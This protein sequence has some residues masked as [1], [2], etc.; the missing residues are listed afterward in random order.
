MLGALPDQ[1]C[2]GRTLLRYIQPKPSPPLLP[3]HLVG[4]K[5][6]SLVAEGVLDAVLKDVLGCVV[7]NGREGIVQQHQVATEVGTAGQVEA[8]TLTSRQVDSAQTS[9]PQQGLHG[10]RGEQILYIHQS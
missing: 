10:V 6:H 4:H 7:V 5:H 1:S 8:L 3:C 9:L 2:Q